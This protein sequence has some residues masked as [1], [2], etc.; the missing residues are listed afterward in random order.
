MPKHFFICTDVECYDSVIIGK[1]ERPQ[2]G[3]K[4]SGLGTVTSIVESVLN[5]FCLCMQIDN[6]TV[7]YLM[8]STS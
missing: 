6:G 2:L 1:C 8:E 7:Y 4:I 3:Q 5:D